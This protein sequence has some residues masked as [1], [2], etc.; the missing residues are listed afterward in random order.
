MNHAAE[1]LHGLI[2]NEIV[3]RAAMTTLFSD[4]KL[5]FETAWREVLETGEWRGGVVLGNGR[6]VE[7]RWSGVRDSSSRLNVGFDS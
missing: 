5:T 6:V 1:E 4:N 3:G 7:T 2:P